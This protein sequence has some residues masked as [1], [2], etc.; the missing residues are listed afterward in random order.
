MRPSHPLPALPTTSVAGPSKRLPPSRARRRVI[1]PLLWR[2][3]HLAGQAEFGGPQ[4]EEP[5]EGV[6]EWHEEDEADEEEDEAYIVG[7]WRRVVEGKVVEEQVVKAKRRRLEEEAVDELV[8]ADDAASDTSGSD[9][10]GR[11]TGEAREASPLF[12][13]RPVASTAQDEDVAEEEASRSRSSSPFFAARPAARR[14]DSPMR[15]KALEVGED[16]A[17]E[18]EDAGSE[19]TEDSADMTGDEATEQLKASSPLFPVKHVPAAEEEDSADESAPADRSTASPLFESRPLPVVP[20]SMSAPAQRPPTAVAVPDP[21]K[22]Q[23]LAEMS[24]DLSLLDSIL[25]GANA[26][27]GDEPV[28]RA[29]FG[30]F[31]ESEDEDED[32]EECQGVLRLRGGAADMDEEMS[33]DDEESDEE[34]DSD[35]DSDSDSSES[36]SSSSS[37][38]SGTDS[39]EEEHNAAKPKEQSSAAAQPLKSMFAASAPTSGGFSLLASLD[40]EL[41]LDELDVPLA[42]SIRPSTAEDLLPLEPLQPGSSVAGLF[43]PDPSI[44]LFFPTASSFGL[45]GEDGGKKGRDGYAEATQADGWKGFWRGEDETEEQ[46]KA[47]WQ[48]SKVVLTKEWKKRHRE[49]KKHRRRRGGVD[50][51]E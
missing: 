32:V 24:R 41:E 51:V 50:E 38:S 20:P 35:S 37:G 33:D 18:Q 7:Q 34:S 36:S 8:F 10:F 27:G 5:L 28:V 30:G 43:D 42:P 1:N 17:S 4:G 25:G 44:P 3:T 48:S 6:W 22:R 23:V 39:G 40:P 15:E 26:F 16:S 14:A 47:A 45:G 21:L 46:M 19:Q 11:H 2:P 12:G 13:D 9:L 29:P 49:A 31:R